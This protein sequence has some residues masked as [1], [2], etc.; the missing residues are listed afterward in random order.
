MHDSSPFPTPE[1]RSFSM[2]S[3]QAHIKHHKTFRRAYM[4][5]F[6]SGG[7]KYMINPAPTPVRLSL[8]FHAQGLLLKLCKLLQ[9]RQYHLVGSTSPCGIQHQ[10]P[11]IDAPNPMHPKH[12]WFLHWAGPSFFI[13]N[14]VPLSNTARSLGVPAPVMPESL[15]RVTNHRNHKPPHLRR[16]ASSITQLCLS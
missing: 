9:I 15:P 10:P 2:A 11:Q 6:I 12:L 3:M 14:Q 4:V 13:R 1:N 8:S 7:W 5:E 16:H